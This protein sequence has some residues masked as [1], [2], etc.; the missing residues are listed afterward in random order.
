MDLFAYLSGV[1]FLELSGADQAGRI[2]KKG[3]YVS[4]A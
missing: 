4:T 1:Q 2:N 3:L